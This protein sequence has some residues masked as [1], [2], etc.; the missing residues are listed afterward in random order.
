MRLFQKNPLLIFFILSIGFITLV[1]LPG[2]LM[3][4]GIISIKVNVLPLM[5]LG[6]WTPNIAA[7]LVIAFI[8]KQKGGIKSLFARWTCFRIAPKWYLAAL[9]P[10]LV[11]IATVM[12]VSLFT[13]IPVSGLPSPGMLAGL[14]LMS[15]ITGATGEELGWRGF[16]LP[17]LLRRYNVII[18]SLILG[19]IWGIWHLPLWFTGMGWEEIPFLMF[20]YLGICMTL[21]I[22][23][24]FINTNGNMVLVTIFHMSFN[25]SLGLITQVWQINMHDAVLYLSIGFT[26]YMLVVARLVV[27]KKSAAVL[28]F[29]F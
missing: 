11:A 8:I 13:T 21:I 22:T 16:A 17:R 12:T 10:I 6:S 14:I 2:I 18:S 7:M 15:F 5:L 20:M 23:W 25:V 29:N 27:S 1:A 4:Y 9:S 19:I 26:I 28:S 24:I 3:N